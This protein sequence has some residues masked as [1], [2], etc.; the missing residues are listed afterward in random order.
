MAVRKLFR[1]GNKLS[2]S[3]EEQRSIQALKNCESELD[4]S[5]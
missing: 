4:K 1:R 5:S 3:K 2:L